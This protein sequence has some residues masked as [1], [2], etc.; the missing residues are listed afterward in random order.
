MIVELDV[1]TTLWA[2]ESSLP[3]YYFGSIFGGI[4]DIQVLVNAEHA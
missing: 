4:L 1:L 2:L 3:L